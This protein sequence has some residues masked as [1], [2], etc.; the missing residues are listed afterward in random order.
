M[1]S[2]P[3]FAEFSDFW[4]DM[5]WVPNGRDPFPD[6]PVCYGGHMAEVL[7][8]LDIGGYNADQIAESIRKRFDHAGDIVHVGAVDAGVRGWAILCKDHHDQGWGAVRLSFDRL[9]LDRSITY[10]MAVLV[11]KCAIC[12]KLYWAH[13]EPEELNQC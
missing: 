11:G 10:G 9:Y 5:E 7:D 13:T 4:P 6:L 2:A 8:G 1:P 12:G 3:V